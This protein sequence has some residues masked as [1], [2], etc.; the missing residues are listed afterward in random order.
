MS[1]LTATDVYRLICSELLFRRDSFVFHVQ[2]KQW[3]AYKFALVKLA[4]TVSEVEI[5]STI[6]L[7]KSEKWFE[8]AS[9][10]D[11]QPQDTQTPDI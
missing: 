11:Y 4:Q 5:I 8:I 7:R 6:M 3:F 2:S 9:D 10:I 1:T